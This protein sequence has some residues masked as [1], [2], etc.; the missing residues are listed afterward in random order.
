MDEDAKPDPYEAVLAWC[1]RF[2]ALEVGYLDG[3]L[4]AARRRHRG[5]GWLTVLGTPFVRALGKPRL[6]KLSKTIHRYDGKNGIVL[7][8]GATPPLGDVARAEFPEAIAEV[9]RMLEPVTITDYGK[10]GALLISGEWFA[11][12]TNELPGAF[13]DHHATHAH[14][15]RFVDPMALVGPTPR[16]KA[17]ELADRLFAKKKK[18]PRD[19]TKT[20]T[21]GSF[22]DVLQALYNSSVTLETTTPLAVEALEFAARYPDSAPAEVYCNLLY[23]YLHTNDMAKG[24]ALL[25]IALRTAKDDVH[26][27]HNAACILV[28]AKKFDEALDCVKR[29]KAGGYEHFAKMQFDED[30]APLA[31]KKAFQDLFADI[32]KRGKKTK[33]AAE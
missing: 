9:A 24:M 6:S 11:T 3:W 19:W 5:A 14:L 1:R 15:R 25:P 23:A 29:A 28:R 22:G 12:S 30:L 21:N 32:P 16:E 2:L 8:A 31:R 10:Q 27:Y 4:T 13:A 20:K 7:R 18:T 17:I 33:P 26:T